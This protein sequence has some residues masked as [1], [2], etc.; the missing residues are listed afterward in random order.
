MSGLGNVFGEGDCALPVLPDV[1]S[2]DVR[3]STAPV[4]DRGVQGFDPRHPRH[5]GQCGH[6]GD[7]DVRDLQPLQRCNILE[8]VHVVDPGAGEVQVFQAGQRIELRQVE[9]GRACQ[10]QG[11]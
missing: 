1:D 10:V 2:L 11:S 6:V 5:G 3:R 7:V 9:D 8:L 4:E